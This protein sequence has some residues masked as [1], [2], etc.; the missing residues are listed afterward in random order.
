MIKYIGKDTESLSFLKDI[1]DI[2][3]VRIM[4]L[5]ECYGG[6]DD[7]ISV[8]VQY[9]GGDKPVGAVSKYGGDMTVWISQEGDIPELRDFLSFTGGSSVLSNERLYDAQERA[10]V[11][12]REGN[13]QEEAFS[14]K[15][16]ELASAYELIKKCSG[17][18]FEAPDYGDFMLDISHRLRRGRAVFALGYEGENP[19]SFAMTTAMTEKYSVIGAVCTHPDMRRKGLGRKCVTELLKKCGRRDMLLLREEGKNREFYLS[20]GFRDHSEAFAMI[21]RKE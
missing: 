6:Y 10:V 1:C 17:K 20:L 15:E 4:A 21:R 8:W 16:E 3:A 18:G 2:C 12:K 5:A 9:D 19:A 13:M 14:Y 11:M 7:I